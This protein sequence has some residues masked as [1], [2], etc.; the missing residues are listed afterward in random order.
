MTPYFLMVR[1][2]GERGANALVVLIHT[3]LIVGIVLLSDN[4]FSSF[5]YLRL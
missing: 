4:D 5:T 3:L 1:W 2:L